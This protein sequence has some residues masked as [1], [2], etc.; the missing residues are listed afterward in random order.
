MKPLALAWLGGGT[1]LHLC[2]ASGSHVLVVRFRDLR[3]TTSGGSQPG[4]LRVLAHMK[5]VPPSRQELF[6]PAVIMHPYIKLLTSCTH[7]HTHTHALNTMM[8]LDNMSC[9]RWLPWK[10]SWWGWSVD[11]TLAPLTCERLP[12]FCFECTSLGSAFLRPLCFC[13]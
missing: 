5:W 11:Q 1:E 9:R 4:S 12:C 7:T 6:V 8:H 2:P 3:P 13:R 10:L